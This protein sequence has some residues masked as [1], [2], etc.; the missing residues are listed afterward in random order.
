MGTK[1][2][3]AKTG[4][5]NVQKTFTG[6]RRLGGIQVNQTQALKEQTPTLVSLPGDTVPASLEG[7]FDDLKIEVNEGEMARE[8]D[9]VLVGSGVMLKENDPK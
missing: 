6:R 7:V 4:I 1:E 8:F 3:D 5:N 2:D 9:N